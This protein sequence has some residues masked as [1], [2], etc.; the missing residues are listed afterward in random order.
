MVG[1][2]GGNS[3]AL[4]REYRATRREPL[5]G[6]NGKALSKPHMVG[7]EVRVSKLVPG[8]TGP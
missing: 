7:A 6:Q 8:D 5:E 3:I 4:K 2:R 1:S